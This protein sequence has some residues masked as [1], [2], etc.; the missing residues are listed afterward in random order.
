MRLFMPTLR[1]DLAVCETYEYHEGAPLDCPISVFGGWQDNGVSCFDLDA[2]RLQT[3]AQFSVRM[4][5][6]DHF[7]I[8][9]AK[10]ELLQAISDD[11]ARIDITSV[12]P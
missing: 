11:L 12:A 5:A 9:G 6:G 7:F 10:T 3:T 4:F 1:A 8:K 2:W